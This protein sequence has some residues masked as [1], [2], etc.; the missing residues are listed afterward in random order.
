MSYD[1]ALTVFSPDGHLFQVEYA[2]EA[3][4]KGTTAVGVR[5]L[6][7]LVLAVEKKAV[8]KLQ[9]PRTMQKICQLD[10][11]LWLAFA[12]LSADAR[13]LINKARVECQS[14]RLTIEDAPSVEYVARHI[15][16]IQQ[17]YTQKGGVRPFGVCTLI[18]GFKD[19]KPRLFL[20]EPS[21]IHSEWRACAI[22]KSSKVVR[23][24]LEK[25]LPIEREASLDEGA[26]IR[27]AVRALLEVVQSGAASVEVAVL[28]G[29]GKLRTL[30]VEEIQA[31]LAEI[32]AEKAAEQE[33]RRTVVAP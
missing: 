10:D 30:K 24:F 16:G 5:G 20:T 3:V 32:E 18:A 7:T 26:T 8:P 29:S 4:N 22:G 2:M 23:E 13:I 9:D 12:G 25:Q 21:G 19:G 14:H 11:H 15:A 27:M 1:R 17:Q 28:D 31:L 6:S 33:R